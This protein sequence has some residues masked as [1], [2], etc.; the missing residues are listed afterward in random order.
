ML[1]VSTW[2]GSFAPGSI[3]CGESGVTDAKTGSPTLR[4]QASVQNSFSLKASV[5][6]QGSSILE[7]P[8]NS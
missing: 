5:A 3:L 1:W 8:E 4:R 6:A 2:M 7:M